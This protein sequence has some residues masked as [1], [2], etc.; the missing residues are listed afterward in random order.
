M[1]TAR[2]EGNT[3]MVSWGDDANEDETAFLIQKIKGQ[4]VSK[5]FRLICDGYNETMV[6]DFTSRPTAEEALS[7]II[8]WQKG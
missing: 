7:T 8:E 5:P 4:P 1:A 2:W 6:K 3:L